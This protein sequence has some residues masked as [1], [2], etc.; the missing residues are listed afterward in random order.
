MLREN[1]LE[2]HR[3]RPHCPEE[4]GPIERADRPLREALG[5]KELT[6]VSTAWRVLARLV[7]RYNEERLHSALGYL[8]TREFYQ[9]EPSRRFEDRRSSCPRPDIGA[10]S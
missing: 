7:R 8:P 3:I 6:D 1:G 10:G 2:H 5:G 4:N 9:G